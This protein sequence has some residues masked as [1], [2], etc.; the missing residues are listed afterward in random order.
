MIGVSIPLQVLLVY[1][2]F[3]QALVQWFQITFLDGKIM[4]GPGKDFPFFCAFVAEFVVEV[5]VWFELWEKVNR[6]WDA[7][8]NCTQHNSDLCVTHTLTKR[9]NLSSPHIIVNHTWPDTPQRRKSSLLKRQQMRIVL[10]SS[11][12]KN[13]HG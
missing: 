5:L 3:S 10:R 11:L 2:L 4:Y 8:E 6:D 12:G 7:L 1:Y 9:M 13:D